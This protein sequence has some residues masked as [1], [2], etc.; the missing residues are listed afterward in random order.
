MKK[1]KTYEYEERA[2]LSE[3]SFG[4][5]KQYLDDNA[6]SKQLDNKQSFFFV[7]PDVNI[8]IAASSTDVKVKYKGGQLGNG[9]G[10][11]EKEFYIVP[12]SLR[13]AIAMF[14]SLLEVSPQESYQFRINYKFDNQIEVALKYTQMWGFHLEVERVYATDA[15][16]L[17]QEKALSAELLDD[18]ANNLGIS[19]ITNKEMSEFKKQC[20]RGQNRGNYSTKEFQGKYGKLFSLQSSQEI[21]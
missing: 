21:F 20:E 2:F 19:Y 18:F 6:L 9:N 15:T 17:E 13:D 12:E 4:K 10:F 11:E 1:S 7:L 8:S 3:D 16:N 14:S 5:T